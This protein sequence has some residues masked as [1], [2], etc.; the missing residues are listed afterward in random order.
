MQRNVSN[1]AEIDY[2]LPTTESFQSQE[3]RMIS[4]DHCYS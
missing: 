4:Y 3:S 2:L 1:G